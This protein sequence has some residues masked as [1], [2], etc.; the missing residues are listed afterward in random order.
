MAKK[1]KSNI[2]AGH[3]LKQI[4]DSIIYY[5]ETNIDDNVGFINSK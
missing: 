4:F 1:Q 5:H 3:K 2:I